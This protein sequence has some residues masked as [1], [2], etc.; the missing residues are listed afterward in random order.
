MKSLAIVTWLGS[1]ELLSAESLAEDS[2]LPSPRRRTWNFDS[3]EP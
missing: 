1:P 2:S 3:L